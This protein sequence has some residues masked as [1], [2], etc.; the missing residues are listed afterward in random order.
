VSRT[1]YLIQDPAGSRIGILSSIRNAWMPGDRLVLHG[2]IYRVVAVVPFEQPD[3]A[4][5]VGALTVAR[6]I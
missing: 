6:T 5:C 1:T 3:D 4:G 2:M